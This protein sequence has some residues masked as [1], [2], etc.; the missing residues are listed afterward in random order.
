MTSRMPNEFSIFD[1]RFSILARPVVQS[2]IENLKSKILSVFLC[3]LCALCVEESALAGQAMPEAHPHIGF[4]YPAGG[5]QGSTFEVKVGG[6]DIY[7]ST[8]VLVSGKGVSIQI[9]DSKE[10]EGA[11]DKDKK[12]NKVKKKN[13]TVIDEIVKLKITIARDAEPV[14]RD[15]CLV[16]PGGLT[17]K[18]VFQVG[19]LK[20]FIE[21]EPNNTLEQACQLPPL[22]VVVN[23]QIMSPDTWVNGQ[24][25]PG[26]GDVDMFRFFARKGQHLVMEA[27]ARGLI[28][29]IADAVPGWFQAILT[30][31]DAQGKELAVADDFRF[32]QDPV[33]FYDVPGDGQY[34]LSIRDSIYRGR[35]DFV[36]RVRIGELPFITSVFPLG[37]PREEKLSSVKLCGRNLP[38]APA[39]VATDQGSALRYLSVMAGG[40]TSNRVPFAIGDLPEVLATEAAAA[41]GQ[42]Q[43]V[44]LPVVINGCIRTP[45][46]KDS[47]CFAGKKGQAVCLE[48]RA[49]RLG[50]PLDSFIV[51]LNSKGEKL[52]ENDDIKDKSEGL[53]THVA[54]SELIWT[55]PED[56]NY[57]A[58]IFDTQGGGGPEYAYRFRIG[59]PVPDFDLRVT[60]AA[61][62]VQRGGSAPLTVHAIRKD[63]FCGEIRLA[64]N[65][66]SSGLSLNGA[67]IQEGTDKIRLTVSASEK[68]AAATLSPTVQGTAVISGKTVTR[69]A[70]PAEDQMQAFIYWHL[71]PRR[72]EVV[73]V[74]SP[75]APFRVTPQLPV[76]G[77][78][79]LAAGKDVSLPVTVTRT[80]GFDGPIRIQ[81]IDPP[82]GVS[83]GGRE[84]I[85]KEATSGV[86]TL[87]A[88][89]DLDVKL[90]DNLILSG[91][92]FL[93][94]PGTP[95]TGNSTPAPTPPKPP[96]KKP[97]EA[98]KPSAPAPPAANSTA[99]PT[100]IT[101]AP[102]RDAPVAAENSAAK[103]PATPPPP[104]AAKPAD[105]KAKNPGEFDRFVVTLPAV[106]FKIS[107]SPDPK[108]T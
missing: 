51:L 50:S 72:E 38:D 60:P 2:K 16:A 83:I 21:S 70:L 57:T 79:E 94:K 10:P 73:M 55:L 35:A 63:G 75:V 32:S 52:A 82:K 49:R 4:V 108:T 15:I 39:I 45:G 40:L 104:P 48:V 9:A 100:E 18:L 43:Q 1:F 53:L 59:P 69:S 102:R 106:P 28:P 93:K 34:V 41:E 96:E 20:E 107:D 25:T 19:Q 7:G 66:T 33:L 44:S 31:Y 23:G 99:T 17:N 6:E 58:R 77:Y 14:P 101:I 67:V 37:G 88:E 5:Q 54:D 30:L 29:Y 68:A 80:S 36:Y 24:K 84:W 8:A 74:T 86:V 78:L 11:G 65:E 71:V 13:Q 105:T 90:K 26:A 61:V 97:A 103:A 89:S 62:S 46:Q 56:G 92:M 3:A 91:S 98:P 76:K 95:S 47:Y 87:H 81:L 64:L 85:G 27:S 12:K 42:A 22:P